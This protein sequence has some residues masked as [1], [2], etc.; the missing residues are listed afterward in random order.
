MKGTIHKIS[1]IAGACLMIAGSVW[2][3]KTATPMGAK[4]LKPS[5]QT[6]YHYTAATK[7]NTKKHGAVRAGSLTWRCASKH[8]NIS[9]PWPVPGVFACHKLAQQVGR[10]ISYGHPGKKLNKAQ[11]RQCNQGVSASERGTWWFPHWFVGTK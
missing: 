10:I 6:Q 11:L 1:L 9:G 8:C 4:D 5:F 7:N 2:A 3:A